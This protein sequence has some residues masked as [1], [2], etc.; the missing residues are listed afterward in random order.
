MDAERIYRF[1]LPG[2]VLFLSIS[3]HLWFFGYNIDKII[4][5]FPNH[6]KEFESIIQLLI[7]VFSSPALGFI[8]SSIPVYIIKL[9]MGDKLNF[10]IPN[11]IEQIKLY[12]EKLKYFLNEKYFTDRINNLKNKHL[13]SLN[14]GELFS[15]EDISNLYRYF[16]Y[17]IREI[18][19]EPVNKHTLRRWNI[20]YLHL[21]I[22]FALLLGIFISIIIFIC[23]CPYDDMINKSCCVLKL[24]L[25]LIFLIYLIS[26]IYFMKKSRKEVIE[27]E[28]DLILNKKI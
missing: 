19:S 12:Y 25:E 10:K 1:S 13:D 27:I 15:K 6:N 24:F 28:C 20:F 21:N 22:S 17:A 8:I 11:N 7:I 3:L 9:Y 4:S 5:I 23:G 26:S 2:I 18:N 16:I 14:N